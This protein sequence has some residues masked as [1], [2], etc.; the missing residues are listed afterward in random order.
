MTFNLS[1]RQLTS[2]VGPLTLSQ[3]VPSIVRA[4]AQGAGSTVE[5][6]SFVDPQLR[7]AAAQAM[8]MQAKNG[9]LNATSL[10]ALRK[11]APVMGPPRLADIPI[12]EHSVTVG[13]GMPPVRVFAV[14]AQ[15]GHKRPAI[16]HMH[17]GGYILGTAEFGIGELQKMAQQL[18]CTIVT[19]DYRLAPE[20]RYTGIIEDN[21]AA[22]KWVYRNAATLGIDP[23][24]I[25]VMGESAGGGLAARLAITARDRGEVPVLFQVL[26]YPMLD[27]RTGST[28]IPPFPM[29]AIGWDA[30]SNRFGWASF[31]GMAPGGAN[32]PAA[33]VPARVTDLGGLAPAFIGVGGIDLFVSEDIAYAKRLIEARVPCEL[34][35]IPGA[36]HGFD[37]VGADTAPARQFTAAKI[38]AL[39]RA[40]G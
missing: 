13:A 18:D 5:P 10:V 4:A 34:L 3:F 26:I 25:A 6:M 17:G 40:F 12:A 7:P 20:T 22:L 37:M 2:V 35:V 19:V 11:G 14:N 8:K 27:D 30:L 16:V 23:N 36:F 21:Y 39:R 28:I 15:A 32:V 29:G 24:R 31:L 1:R 9:P 33:G 38:E